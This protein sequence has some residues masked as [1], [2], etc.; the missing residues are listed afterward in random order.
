MPAE[1]AENGLLLDLATERVL[2]EDGEA[3]RGAVVVLASD[4]KIV[5]S[6]CRISGRCLR[7]VWWAPLWAEHC[8]RAGWRLR[9]TSRWPRS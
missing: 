1:T 5:L 8:Y 4:A 9:C 3:Q 6:S 7:A 2:D